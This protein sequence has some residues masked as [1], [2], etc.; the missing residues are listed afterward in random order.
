MTLTLIEQGLTYQLTQFRSFQRRFF[1]GLM[2]Q[3]I[4]SKHLTIQYNN[5]TININVRV[6]AV[7]SAFKLCRR[8]P[9]LKLQLSAVH[10][11]TV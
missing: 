8:R 5:K 6:E 10:H 9:S 7:Y 11:F 3:P 2:T 4:V 1:T